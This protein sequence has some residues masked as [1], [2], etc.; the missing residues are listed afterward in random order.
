MQ[1]SR[2][3]RAQWLL[4]Q[5]MS[6]A[7]LLAPRCSAW[8]PPIR[9]GSERT[10]KRCRAG[11]SCRTRPRGRRP[12]GDER[13]DRDAPARDTYSPALLRKVLAQGLLITVDIPH[14]R[15]GPQSATAH[16]ADPNGY[17]VAADEVDA[18]YT[19]DRRGIGPV[20]MRLGLG[21]EFATGTANILV[22]GT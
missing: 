13:L 16:F 1:L 21:G 3:R 8:P 11:W 19:E 22:P 6:L 10:G 15:R 17:P 9:P 14:T 18:T 2:H 7:V 4:V 12:R 20:P 5:P